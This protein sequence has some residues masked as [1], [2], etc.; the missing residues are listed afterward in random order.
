[1]LTEIGYR[2][3]SAEDGFTALLEIHQEIPAILLTDLNMSGISG[4]ELLSVVRR[5]F[6]SIQTIAMSGSF[7]GNEVPSG[8]VADAFYE[9]GS[10]VG[11]LL[12]IITRLSL[13]EKRNAGH[14]SIKTP[15]LMH[16]PRKNS[17]GEFST[18]NVSS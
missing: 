18:A 3:R 15:V 12:Q 11:A 5:C 13:M 16:Q 2:V 10:S 1:V 9:K 14:S 4:I 6:P 7:S 17:P 8:V